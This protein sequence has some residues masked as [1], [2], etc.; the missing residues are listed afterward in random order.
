MPTSTRSRVRTTFREGIFPR[1]PAVKARTLLLPLL[2]AFTAC[3]SNNVSSRD[4]ARR[5]Y[6][7]VDTSVDKALDLGFQGFNDA[8]SANIPP[9]SDVGLLSGTVT[10][11]G[12]V[13]QGASSNKQMRLTMAMA[14]YSDLAHLT[15][16][17]T[18]N[19]NGG[20]PLPV[21]D[22]SLQGIPD[23]TLS[24]TL[25]GTLQISGD[26]SGSV[27]LDLSFTGDLTSDAS[28]GT[29][30]IIRKAGTTHITG[31]ATSAAGVFAVDVRQ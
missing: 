23:G 8:K 20:V 14:T 30:R 9:E 2:L 5:A 22:M 24:G 1:R 27:T 12:Q 16:D 10:V 26:L 18:E 13:D 6:L 25:A 3:G 7:G 21:L 31:T 4:D 15:Y 11:A 28:S 19:Q 29:S 17:T